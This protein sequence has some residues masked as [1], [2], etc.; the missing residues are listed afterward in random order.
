MGGG[1]SNMAS[2]SRKP[3]AVRLD[4]RARAA[5]SFTARLHSFLWL[6]R[7]RFWHSTL[8]YF[9]SLHA[10][11][12]L[13]ASPTSPHAAHDASH[14]VLQSNDRPGKRMQTRRSSRHSGGKIWWP[15]HRRGARES[16][17]DGTRRHRHG[18]ALLRLAAGRLRFAFP[19]RPRGG[20]G[21][22]YVR[23]LRT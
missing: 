4:G 11:H 14:I 6:A 19:S 10:E 7:S 1:G 18:S 13:S 17:V 23:L 2:S 5:L 21:G 20:G 16:G 9:T 22:T 15:R 12:R 3:N 8:Q